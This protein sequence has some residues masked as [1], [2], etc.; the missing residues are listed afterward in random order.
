MIVGFNARLLKPGLAEGLNVYAKE[1]IFRL[2]R[3]NPSWQFVLFFDHKNF[4]EFLPYENMRGIYVPPPSRQM[5][6]YYTW[7]HFTLPEA[8]VSIKPDVFLSP[9]PFIPVG[10]GVPV[11]L[12]M[13]DIAYLYEFSGLSLPYRIYYW[14]MIN[15]Y[16]QEATHIIANS[17]YTMHQTRKLYSLPEEKFTVVGLGIKDFPEPR[18]PEFKVPERFFLYY[19]ALQPRKNIPKLLQAF[20]IVCPELDSYLIV[21]GRFAWEYDAIID[22]WRKMKC[23]NRV[24]FTGTL[25]DNQIHYLLKKAIALVFPSLMEGF[26]LPVVEAQ[27]VGCPVITSNT[28]ALPEIGGEGALFVDPNDEHNIAEAMLSVAIDNALRKKLIKAGFENTKRF[29]WEKTTERIEEIIK[30]LMDF[31]QKRFVS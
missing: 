15:K 24:L 18:E 5:I 17:Y 21:A 27:K 19:G 26:G 28:S 11:V 3:R 16:V 23:R 1:V 8:V 10:T 20:D 29:S 7:F 31:R 9:E 22:Q 2:A 12:T 4:K 25:P 14:R 6:L 13:H 30:R